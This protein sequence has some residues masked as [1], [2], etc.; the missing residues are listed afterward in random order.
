[1]IFAAIACVLCP[2]MLAG[3]PVRFD[4]EM[5]PQFT[6]HQIEVVSEATRTGIGKWAHTEQAAKLIPR[7]SAP[8]YTI[9]VDED[10]AEPSPGRAPQPGIATLA[11][12][13]DHAKKKTYSIVLNPS[14]FRVTKDL[15]HFADEPGSAA[16][17][18]AAAFA[19]EML[20]L[21]FY[22]RGISLPHHERPDFQREWRAIASDLGMP[23]LRHDDDDERAFAPRRRPFVQVIGRD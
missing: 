17:V 16:D 6:Q 12:A 11:A 10:L 18:M 13:T 14:F 2:F 19:A 3:E 21:D 15:A 1:M 22:S 8:E 23:A 5:R 4:A 7:F 20:H 9:A